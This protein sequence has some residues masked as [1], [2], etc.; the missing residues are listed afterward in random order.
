MPK[1]YGWVREV[2]PDSPAD[3]AGIQPG[4]LLKTINGRP[5][6]DLV[7]YQ[8]YASEE[9]LLLGVER[10]GRAIE[11]LVAK[12]PDEAMGI[13]FGEEPAPFIRICANKCV[14][15]FI[16]G[17]PER[18]QPQRGLPLGMR[19]SLYIKDDDYRYS[20]LFGN[21]IT[22][23]NLKEQD[24]RRLEEQRLSPLY[25][26]VHTTDPD[27]RR[28]MVDGPRSGE[29]IEQIQRLGD[30]GITCHTQL[31]LCPG[32]NDGDALDRSIRDLA[33]LRP[34]VESISVVPVGLTKY[35]NMIAVE[36]LPPLRPY[37]REEADA[38]VARVE[39]WQ[40][41]FGAEPGSHSLPFVYL[42]DEWYYVTRRAF[43]PA[44]HYGG[45]AQI[46]NGVG[47]TRKL[48]DD[49]R[50]AKRELAP[51]QPDAQSDVAPS[52]PPA[53]AGDA[54]LPQPASMPHV[55]KV[56]IITSA[57]AEPVMKRIAGDIRRTTGLDVRVVPVINQFFGPLVT[58]A[59]LICGQDAL[60]TI[61]ATCA[62]FDEGDL[63]LLPR[64]MLDTAGTRFL[65][66]ITVAEF[67][68]R[69]RTP[70]IFAKTA[71]ELRDA[72]SS[73]PGGR[74]RGRMLPVVAT[75]SSATG[76]HAGATTPAVGV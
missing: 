63:L 24:W 52:T 65:D 46:E 6:R 21:F 68:T 32:A 74:A 3:L 4:D 11:T 39:G 60:D 59:G 5:V 48:L 30:L 22:L 12:A 62:D 41:Q 69:V 56:A 66:D 34:I 18:H 19:E 75:S 49:W 31:V 71:E 23:T 40:R 20:F 9:E 51:R 58:V 36:N 45:Y 13:H 14:F 67:R 73:S 47:M 53:V 76:T 10:N 25:V 2:V 26:S 54:S 35:N 15:C 38:I 64:V 44:R 70:V 7:D 17:L 27:L 57:M 50:V 55:R 29:I 1:L 43:P 72:L 33:A 16:K 8:F 61:A 28:K 42:S 37:T